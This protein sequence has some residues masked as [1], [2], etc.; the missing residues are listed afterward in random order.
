MKLTVNTSEL[1]NL[2][3]SWDA[4]GIAETFITELSVTLKTLMKHLN[5]YM[6][7]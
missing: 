4:T 1:F 5:P 7:P 6:M 2:N 3:M